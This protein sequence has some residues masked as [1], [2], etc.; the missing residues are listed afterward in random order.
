MWQRSLK[1]PIGT[2]VFM[3]PIHQEHV[4]SAV[5]ILRVVAVVVVRVRAVKRS[6]TTIRPISKMEVVSAS[7]IAGRNHN[8]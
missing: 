8:E 5:P 2:V 3:A 7:V 1:R 4:N 6:A